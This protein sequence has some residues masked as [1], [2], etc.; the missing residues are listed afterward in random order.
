MRCHASFGID[1]NTQ[2]SNALHC[3]VGH[4]HGIQF[5]LQNY[6]APPPRGVRRGSHITSLLN[7][8]TDSHTHTDF[9]KDKSFKAAWRRPPWGPRYD[10]QSKVQI[11]TVRI[12]APQRDT[13]SESQLQREIQTLRQKDYMVAVETWHTQSTRLQSQS[14]LHLPRR[15]ESNQS[16]RST[17]KYKEDSSHCQWCWSLKAEAS[18][19]KLLV[20]TTSKASWS[21]CY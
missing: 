20:L 17:Q 13:D 4:W 19:L 6:P 10:S 21:R 2:I 16:V 9:H 15:W 8:D 11:A 7:R 12:T 1:S 3:P 5:N 14:R 18:N